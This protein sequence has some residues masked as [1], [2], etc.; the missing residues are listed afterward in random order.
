MSEKKIAPCGIDCAQ[1]DIYKATQAESNEMRM[2]V[3]EKWTKLFHYPFKKEDINCDSCLGGG[4][5][6]IYCQTMCTIRPCALQKGVINCKDCPDYECDILIQ[7]RKE[8][9]QYFSE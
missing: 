7:N 3:A 2:E 8:S 6:G 4:R 5:M 1:C 9:E